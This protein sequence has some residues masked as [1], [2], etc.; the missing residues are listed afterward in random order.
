MS[1]FSIHDSYCTFSQTLFSFCV[2][3]LVYHLTALMHLERQGIVL[4]F[5]VLCFSWCSHCKSQCICTRW[6]DVLQERSCCRGRYPL[7]VFTVMCFSSL[8]TLCK[9]LV[10]NGKIIIYW[11][12]LCWKIDLVKT[13]STRKKWIQGCPHARSEMIRKCNLFQMVESSNSCWRKS[14]KVS[15]KGSI[16]LASTS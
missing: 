12:L 11:Q 2:K 13:L 1:C 16:F 7:S 15:R 8:W 4:F 6:A 5:E 3:A 9:I 10:T 14:Q